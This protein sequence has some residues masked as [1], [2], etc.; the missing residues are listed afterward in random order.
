MTWHLSDNGEWFRLATRAGRVGVWDWDIADD[1]V[2]WSDVVYEIHGLEPG[3]FRGTVGHFEELVHPDDRERVRAAIGRALERDEPYEVEFR[4]IRPDGDV[5]WIYTQAEVERDES[6][7]PVRLHGATVDVTRRKRTEEAQQRQLRQL[8][9][10][11]RLSAAVGRAADVE[12]IIQAAM[13]GLVDAL[14]ADRASVLLFDDEGVM[15]FRGSKGLSEDYRRAVDGHSPWKPEDVEAEPI[16]VTDASVDPAMSDVRDVILGEGIRGLA[17]IPLKSAGRV[18]GKFMVYFDT[19]HEFEPEEIQLCETIAG[20]VTYAIERA[21]TERE[22]RESSRRKDEF[23]AMLGHE[24]RNPLGPLRNMLDVLSEAT[25]D[26]ALRERAYDTMRRQVDQL[27]RLVDDLL[28]VSRISRGVIKLRPERLEL[29]ALVDETAR[30]FLPVASRKRQ[31]LDVI[32]ADE[33]VRV[34]ADPTRVIQVVENLL[35]NASKFTGPGG[36]ISV[37]VGREDGAGVLRVHDTG[38]GIEP[39]RLPHVFERFSRSGD[40]REGPQLE[41][42]GIGLSLVRSLVDLHGGTIEAH[43]EGRGHGAEFVVRLPLAPEAVEPPAEN[44]NSVAES[45]PS[46]R[47]RRILVVDDNR[48]AADTLSLLLKHRGHDV[49]TVF[50]GLEAVEAAASLRPDVILLDLGLPKLS[51]V[52]AARRIRADG[53]NGGTLLVALTGWSQ[54]EDRRRSEAAGFDAHLVKP[55]ELSDLDRLLAHL[56]GG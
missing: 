23:L 53:A 21:R 46:D 10:I 4:T 6:G 9:T 26:E 18:I 42:L 31:E 45:R 51:G 35:S 3:A 34:A 56:D 41:G 5:V 29:G 20:H 55:L 30:S 8:R 14:D 7:A 24:L 12:E 11:Y 50:D 32:L 22:L 33:P 16:A 28:D 49:H 47:G 25:A 36:R 27:T 44:G 54:D 19:P 15:R 39:E 17:F 48:D 40:P 38:V 13:D 2:T 1:A 37:T 43:S 52:D